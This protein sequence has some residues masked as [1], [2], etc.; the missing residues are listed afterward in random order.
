MGYPEWKRA[1]KVRIRKEALRGVDYA[2][3]DA[4]HTV[5]VTKA[6]VRNA[7][8]LNISPSKISSQ[9][10]N[11]S[12]S[13]NSENFV[14]FEGDEETKMRATDFCVGALALLEAWALFDGALGPSKGDW[15]RALESSEAN[16][17]RELAAAPP[18]LAHL[19]VDRRAL[20][21]AF[22]GMKVYRFLIL[23]EFLHENGRFLVFGGGPMQW[24][25]VKKEFVD[26]HGKE[27]DDA[28]VKAFD[29]VDYWINP[30]LSE[31]RRLLPIASAEEM[32]AKRKSKNKIIC[33]PMQWLFYMVSLLIERQ[34]KL[35][36]LYIVAMGFIKEN[37]SRA[38]TKLDALIGDLAK[39][40]KEESDRL[41]AIMAKLP[42]RDDLIKALCQLVHERDPEGKT[43][44]AQSLKRYKF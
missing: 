28:M 15:A 1:R 4:L 39:Q 11:G 14:H 16:V 12:E 42:T 13:E 25:H 21:L 30:T 3:K 5:E 40:A 37:R 27:Y 24:T 29:R 10:E 43:E 22:H 18:D 36:H 31:V 2:L 19:D 33:E 23:A 20:C 44:Y 8:V 34:E 32:G 17:A 35:Q 26:K 7:L 6:L 38:G 41:R 9:S